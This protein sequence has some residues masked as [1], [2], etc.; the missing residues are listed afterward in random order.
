ML[1]GLLKQSSFSLNQYHFCAALS[2]G[3]RVYSGSQ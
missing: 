1:F 3:L 2:L